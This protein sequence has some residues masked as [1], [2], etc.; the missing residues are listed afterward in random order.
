MS[1]TIIPYTPLQEMAWDDFCSGSV[2]STFLHTRRFLSYHGDRFADVSVLIMESDKVVGVFPAAIS[3]SDET[4]VVSHPGITYGGIVHRGRLNGIRMIEALL[5]LSDYYRKCGYHRLQYKVVPYIYTTIP[6]QDDLY[7]L[8]RLGAKRT[9]CD[10]ACTIDLANRQPLSE[11]RRRALKKA[12][13]TVIFSSDQSLLVELWRVVEQNLVRKHDAIAAH[14]LEELSQLKDRFPD[15]ISIRCALLDGKVEAGVILFNSP[16]AW[17]A[18][19]IA[20]SERGYDVSALD[21]VFDAAISQA[22]QAGVRYFDFGTSNEQ[23]GLVLNDGLYRFKS[24]FGGCGV[25]HEFYELDLIN[26]Q[27]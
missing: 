5:T 9:R 27:T 24:E 8:F 3:P 15:H 6:S 13:K 18:Q 22:T 19:Y 14:S 16:L 10:L 25:A 20:S 11:R 12:S 1:I 7:A 4:L 2:N 26:K 21:A 17:H 23:A